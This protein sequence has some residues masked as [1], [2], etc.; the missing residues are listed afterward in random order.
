[1]SAEF[2]R[3]AYLNRLE[4]A[5]DGRPYSWAAKHGVPKHLMTSL[6]AITRKPQ[7]KTLEL[8][9]ER[10]GL[11]THWLMYGEGQQWLSGYDPNPAPTEPVPAHQSPLSK[12]EWLFNRAAG[13]M[14][15]AG[16]AQQEPCAPQAPKKD[17]PA[18]EH[19]AKRYDRDLLMEVVIALEE[20]FEEEGMQPT[21]E[22]RAKLTALLYEISVIREHIARDEMKSLLKVAA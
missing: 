6:L 10:T 16:A 14:G 9:E 12:E 7:R 21:P 19:M 2:D 3:D 17:E 18:Q 11:S 4:L 15:T 1:M 8:I 22:R 5:A 13:E 20:F